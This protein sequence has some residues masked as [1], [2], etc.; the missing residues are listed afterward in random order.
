[1]LALV[2]GLVAIGVPLLIASALSDSESTQLV[3]SGLPASETRELPPFTSIDLAGAG[4]VTVQV[5]GAQSVV[6]MADDN[7]LANVTTSVQDG[8]LVIATRGSFT[9]TTPMTV[10]VTMPSLDELALSLSGS[11][12]VRATGTVERLDVTLAG[13]GD[14]ELAG[15][16]ARDVQA[17]L[18]GSGRI[19]VHATGTLDAS[20]PGTG[21][22][23]YT[24]SPQVTQS[25]AG[26]GTITGS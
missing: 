4:A 24:G 10:A 12:L 5:G 22:I 16:V 1:V 7:L 25:V 20:L 9:T 2:L 19:V 18:S 13:S 15:L 26:T 8:E 21:T 14:A 6:V 23:V 17:L 11:G 3:G